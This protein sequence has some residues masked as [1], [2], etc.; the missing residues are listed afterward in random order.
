MSKS[1]PPSILLGRI[2]VLS[3][4]C[5]IV[6]HQPLLE[7]LPFPGCGS[8]WRV[9]NQERL[10]PHKLPPL[11][12]SPSP[13]RPP[14]R[15]NRK[16]SFQFQALSG[17]NSQYSIATTTTTGPP[18]ALIHSPSVGLLLPFL[19][20]HLSSL[21]CRPLSVRRSV[22][23]DKG[24]VVNPSTCPPSVASLS[25]TIARRLTMYLVP[26][27]S[28]FRYVRR[29][30]LAI[31]LPIVQ[32]LCSRLCGFCGRHLHLL[33]VASHPQAE[34]CPK[35]LPRRFALPVSPNSRALKYNE[36]HKV[37]TQGAVA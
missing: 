2:E 32:H 18:P 21:C 23:G 7:Y 33:A 26:G 15:Q 22:A 34:L 10:V 36:A 19:L 17:R 16:H 8:T 9:Q 37:P 24:N 3:H 14:T 6:S 35:N 12:R 30:Q 1:F 28:G 31:L 27:P 4:I 25:F 29:G 5:V 20:L 13:F 11:G